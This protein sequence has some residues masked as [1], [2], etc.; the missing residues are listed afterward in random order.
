MQQLTD[1]VSLHDAW[2]L[3]MWWSGRTRF[4]ITLLPESDPS[5]L[6]VL[7]YSLLE[8][9]AVEQDVLPESVRSEPVAWLYDELDFKDNSRRG[10]ATFTQRILLSDG[11]E[12]GL[13]F[14]NVSVM[15][16]VGLVPASPANGTNHASVRHSA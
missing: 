12:V 1:S 13:H 16:P 14:R 2:V 7:T 3:D 4:G 15:R 5:R 10:G 11:R 6:V 9:P 8:P